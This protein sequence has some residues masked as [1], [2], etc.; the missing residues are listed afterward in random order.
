MVVVEVYVFCALI[1]CTYI[2]ESISKAE[3]ISGSSVKVSSDREGLKDEGSLEA[4]TY[5]DDAVLRKQLHII[6]NTP[7]PRPSPRFYMP[8]QSNYP[9]NI[10][11]WKIIQN[12]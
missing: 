1:A 6:I 5:L 4:C 11:K 7:I 2:D 12:I 10:L 3:V 8:T 9:Q